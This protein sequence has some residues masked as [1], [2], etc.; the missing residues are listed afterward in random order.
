[1]DIIYVSNIVRIKLQIKNRLYNILN[2]DILFSN[3]KYPRFK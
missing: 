2:I 1:M 3:D